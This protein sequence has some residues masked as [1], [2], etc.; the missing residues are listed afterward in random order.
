MSD[1]KINLAYFS[2]TKTTKNVLL[3]IAKGLG[4]DVAQEVDFTLPKNV[5]EKK[6]G[7]DDLVV[8]GLPVYGGRIPR[9]TEE[10]IKKIQG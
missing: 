6:F 9:P 5:A 7:P 8:F 1:R 4:G 10:R 2:P 3:S